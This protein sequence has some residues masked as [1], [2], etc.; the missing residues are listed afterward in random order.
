MCAGF[1]CLLVNITKVLGVISVKVHT[2]TQLDS[3]DLHSYG[4]DVLQSI[5]IHISQRIIVC[6]MTSV[7]N[8][9]Q[10]FPQN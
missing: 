6:A 3:T 8:R 5:I 4:T 9:I 7:N 1:L 2:V 10:D